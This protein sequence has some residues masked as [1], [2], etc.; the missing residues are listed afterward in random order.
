MEMRGVSKI[1]ISLEGK[2]REE[3]LPLLD[4]YTEL[5]S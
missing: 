2:K 1:I 4:E 5:I 3:A